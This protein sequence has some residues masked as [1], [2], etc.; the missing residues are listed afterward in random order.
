MLLRARHQG[1]E[2]DPEIEVLVAELREQTVA[3]R[4]VDRRFVKQRIAGDAEIGNQCL[5]GEERLRSDPLAGDTLLVE[6]PQL[7]RQNLVGVVGGELNQVQGEAD[8]GC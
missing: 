2:R 5:E 1:L 6:V 3:R 4:P 8:R 7:S